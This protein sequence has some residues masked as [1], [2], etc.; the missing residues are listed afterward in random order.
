MHKQNLAISILI[1]LVVIL[2]GAAIYFAT[3]EPA[4]PSSSTQVTPPTT[5]TT[6][7]PTTTQAPPTTQPPASTPQTNEQLFELSKKEPGTKLYISEKLGV[8]FTYD[9]TSDGV[10]SAVEVTE[11]GNTI[12]V[13]LSGAPITSGQWV[14]VFDKD[15]NQTIEQA[16]TAQFLKGIDPKKCFVKVDVASGGEEANHITATIAYPQPVP[17]EGPGIIPDSCPQDYSQ[18]NGIRH[19][20]MDKESP[21]KLLFVSIG[22]YV[23]TT[24]GIPKDPAN[25]F[26]GYS[27]H[28]SIRVVE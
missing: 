2:G 18:T 5:T 3:Q 10:T 15:P 13:Q 17:F 1:V 16:I 21:N 6:P 28:S 20:I 25:K 22:Q 4:K 24:D 12:Y 8:G 9:P 23:L 27:W 26:Y 11:V 7:A 19:F 14:E